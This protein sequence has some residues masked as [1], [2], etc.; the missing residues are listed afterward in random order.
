[1]FRLLPKKFQNVCCCYRW[2]WWWFILPHK[3]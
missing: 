1:L 2:W 3:A